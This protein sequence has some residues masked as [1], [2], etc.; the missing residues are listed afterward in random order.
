MCYSSPGSYDARKH[1]HVAHAV[2][3]PLAAAALPPSQLLAAP[4]VQQLHGAGAAAALAGEGANHA[5]V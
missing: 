5:P 1:C 4:P 3:P 2:Q